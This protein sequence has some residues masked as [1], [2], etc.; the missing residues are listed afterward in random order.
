M[1]AQESLEGYREA[2][3][4]QVQSSTD[5]DRTAARDHATSPVR[6]FV[7]DSAHLLTRGRNADVYLINDT[8]VLR[9]LHTGATSYPNVDLVLHLNAHD[10]PTARVITVEG[11][12]LVMERLHGPTLLQ[13]LDAEE[14]TIP[15]GVRILLDLHSALHA[16]PLPPGAA[17]PAGAS[18]IHLD[19]HP[20][21]ILLTSNGPRVIDWESA[22]LGPAELDL[23]TTALVFAE[24]VVDGNEYAHAAHSMLRHFTEATGPGYGGLVAQAAA[25]R[26][27][28]PT[29]DPAER[30]L[31][32]D[33]IV[34][35]EQ[36]LRR[37]GR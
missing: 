28:H 6:A 24:V 1:G 18:M 35:V 3:D 20:G 16:L 36:E 13:A 9:R 8:Q 29:L 30:E 14:V 12:D 2:M 33:A 4:A 23:A 17:P 10:Y 15:E 11:T 31:L 19:L 21:N 25:I 34:V 22:R 5:D 26:S 27:A 32:P 7:P 37:L